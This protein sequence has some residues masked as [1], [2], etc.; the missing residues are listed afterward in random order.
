ML[1]SRVKVSCSRI[2]LD[3]SQDNHPLSTEKA[4]ISKP[5]AGWRCSL[6][7]GAYLG[8][9]L[10][11]KKIGEVLQLEDQK[12]GEDKALIRYFSVPCSPTKTNGGRTRNLPT[13]APEKWG[14]FK[15]YNKR[16]VEVEMAIQ[17]R[18]S[19]F[20]V[21]GFVWDEYHIDQEID[22]RGIRVD[23]PLVEQ[24]ISMDERS[25]AALTDELKELT[26]LERIPIQ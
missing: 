15:S 19:H 16:D 9:P 20:P 7:W 4:K 13:D 10:S 17:K 25:K 26:G 22:D 8:L 18:L 11:L 14:V 5:P 23:M 12:M 1:L 3:P 6:V 24:A 2:S 21:P